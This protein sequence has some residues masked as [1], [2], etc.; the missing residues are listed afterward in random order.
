MSHER[1]EVPVLLVIFNRPK[2]TGETLDAIRKIKPTKLYVAADGPRRNK[3]GEA[4]LCKEVRDLVL[5]RIDW[6][7][8]VKTL[9][10]EENI[11]CGRG[12]SEAVTWFFENE[13]K[14]I[15]L[16][17]DCVASES[18][19]YFCRDLL[20]YYKDNQKVMHISGN[21][22]QDGIKR[23]KESYFF[24]IYSHNWGWATWKRAWSKMDYDLNTLEEFIRKNLMKKVTKTPEIKKYWL[25]YLVE[26]KKK[27]EKAHVWDVQWMYSMWKE[28]GLSILPNVNL[29]TNI[30]SGQDATHTVE[31]NHLNIPNETMSFPLLHPKKV[32]AN[33]KADEYT[34]INVF[35]GQIKRDILISKLKSYLKRIIKKIIWK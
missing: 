24:S 19:F 2:T 31:A 14:G 9:F 8:E 13:E 5:S 25:N 26:F 22:F 28:A 3:I 12:V 6:E 15:I 1:F 17:D 32:L 35:Y 10:R 18:F 29:V 30:G 7:C 23:G 4:E 16:E 11:G 27:N 21:N 33:Q 34:H 20:D